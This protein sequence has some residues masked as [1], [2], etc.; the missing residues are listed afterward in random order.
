MRTLVALVSTMTLVIV[1]V[2]VS[3]VTA[4]DHVRAASGPPRTV[5]QLTQTFDDFFNLDLG[6]PGDSLGDEFGVTV[7]WFKDGEKV[8]TVGGTCTKTIV[9]PQPQDLCLLSARFADG[10]LTAQTLFDESSPAPAEW[11]ITG[12]TGAYRNAGGF[13]TVAGEEITLHIDRL[14]P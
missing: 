14:A 9:Q 4:Q 12:G 7:S 8:A 3:S 10:L 1:S 6:D 2:M 13:L 5:L 11:A